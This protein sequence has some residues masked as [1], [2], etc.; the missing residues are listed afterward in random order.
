[1]DFAKFIFRDKKEAKFMSFVAIFLFVLCLAKY[2]N[3]K[4]PGKRKS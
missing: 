3:C 1:M 2:P 4:I